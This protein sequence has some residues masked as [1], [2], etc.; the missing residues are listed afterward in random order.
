M[1]LPA[2]PVFR[3][4]IVGVDGRE[5]GTDAVALAHVLAAPD[6]EIILLDAYPFDG[7]AERTSIGAYEELLREG[8]LN[9][10]AVEGDHEAYVRRAVA[11]FSPGRALQ[12]E[13]E[14]SGADL[15]VIGSC[16]RG[17]LGG[18]LVGDVSRA[19]LHG[20]PCPVA[21]APRGY[22]NHEE[23]VRV[24]GVGVDQ[25]AP[26]R[27]AL[28]LAAAVAAESG[29]ALRLICAV[30]PPAA[31]ITGFAYYD[32]SRLRDEHTVAASRMQTELIAELGVPATGEVVEGVAAEILGKLSRTADL[33]VVGSRGRGA[34]RRVM[35]GSTSDRLVHEAACPVLVMPSPTETGAERETV[36]D[37]GAPAATG[38]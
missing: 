5:G 27:A 3:K 37:V 7:G 8:A 30:D 11:D 38:S 24:I 25:R 22:R 13:A 34:F 20:A 4:V 36:A 2:A 12:H 10:L 15:I 26:A 19:V 14:S 29:G 1:D 35:L 31:G 9:L 21:V 6:A 18:V 16:H 23:P 28:E 33:I 17:A 32:W